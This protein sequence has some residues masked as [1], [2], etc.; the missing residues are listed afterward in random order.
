MADNLPLAYYTTKQLFDELASRF[1][2][3]LFCG[4][5]DRDETHYQLTMESKGTAPEILGLCEIASE[6]YKSLVKHSNGD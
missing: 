1:D 6:H 4:Y 3:F 5:M 2:C